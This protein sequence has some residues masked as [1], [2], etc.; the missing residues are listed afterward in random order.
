MSH[1]HKTIHFA[2]TTTMKSFLTMDTC[3]VF[4]YLF[5][6]TFINRVCHVESHDFEIQKHVLGVGRWTLEINNKIIF[7]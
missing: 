2:T 5:I 3:L 4:I 7:T 1:C 6:L